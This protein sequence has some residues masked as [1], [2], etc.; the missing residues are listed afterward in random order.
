VHPP[1]HSVGMRVL[2]FLLLQTACGVVSS[3]GVESRGQPLIIGADNR[4]P[5]S[6]SVLSGA[7]QLKAIGLVVHAD[8]PTVG[9][10]TGFKISPNLV[11]T[12]AH[13]L[14]PD[15]DSSRLRFWPAAELNG[16]SGPL[17][18]YFGPVVSITRVVRGT[19]GLRAPCLGSVAC[20]AWQCLAAP[21]SGL[22]CSAFEKGADFALLEVSPASFFRPNS[23]VPAW[24][25]VPSLTL[26]AGASTGALVTTVA[27][28][29]LPTLAN[30]AL[31]Q[32]NCTLGTHVTPDTFWSGVMRTDCDLNEGASGAPV[33][34]STGGTSWTES[35]VVAM[36]GVDA[37]VGR[38]PALEQANEVFDIQ[39]V[40]GSPWDAVGLA[41]SR[42]DNGTMSIFATDRA[43]PNQLMRRA[44]L[45]A[46]PAPDPLVRLDSWRDFRGGLSVPDPTR[47]AATLYDGRQFV[48]AVGA[49]QRVYANWQQTPN[50]SFGGWAWFFENDTATTSVIDVATDG[51]TS[52]MFVYLLRSNGTL[53]VKR[54]WA[55]WAGPWWGGWS[56]VGTNAGLLRIS[57]AN[58][59]SYPVM[60][61]I[62]QTDAV[63]TWAQPDG[64]GWVGLQP[65]TDSLPSGLCNKDIKIGLTPTGKLDVFLLAH[66]N[67]D[68]AQAAIFRRT[69]TSAS[70]GSPWGSWS[71]YRS[72]SDTDSPELTQATS[73]ALL[74]PRA[75]R[76]DGIVFIS[77]GAMFTSGWNLQTP[78]TFLG[79]TPFYGPVRP[80]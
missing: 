70:A 41:A 79:W 43:R 23:T 7:P 77:R 14:S 13:C 68:P 72:T 57:A 15:V 49:D 69:K 6:T 48:F 26:E 34:V 32:K 71:R 39:S 29:T 24:D 40:V 55:G 73:L 20:G 36:V 1:V 50:S 30:T 35:R 5:V 53:A 61:G 9:A 37:G 67:C 10:C 44:E 60:V 75:Q 59:E 18:N 80:W 8:H 58:T 42:D 47:L 16:A 25:S 63:I 27:Y 28:Q 38:S 74:P 31:A 3:S 62:T 12:A 21:T 11:V 56:V 76:G 19:G 45:V 33:M 17:S 52:S 78:P 66:Q 65:F 4:V 64:S 2:P 51:S 54:K 22:A 46:T